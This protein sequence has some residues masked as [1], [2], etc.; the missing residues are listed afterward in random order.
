MSEWDI[1]WFKNPVFRYRCIRATPLAIYHFGLCEGA[2]WCCIGVTAWRGGTYF[3][4]VTLRDRSADTLVRHVGLLRAV[5]RTVRAERPF[6]INAIV[7]LPDHLHTLW[8]LP[9]GDSGY[10]GRWRAIK[11]RFTRQLV[12][13]GIPLDCGH[14]GEYTLWQRRFWEHAL[15][16]DA[17]VQHHADYSHWN[18]TR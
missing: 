10:S 9:D 16:D 2:L 11:P 6:T 15:C 1:A 17:D 12:Q 18:P 8:T 14:R 7:I 5:F 13:S 3:F 4:T